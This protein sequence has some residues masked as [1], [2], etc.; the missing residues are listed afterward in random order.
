MNIRKQTKRNAKLIRG[1]EEKLDD[2]Y[3]K[4]REAEIER[5]NIV[6]RTTQEY[7]EL[8]RKYTAIVAAHQ[9][10]MDITSNMH[11]QLDRLRAAVNEY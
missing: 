11:Y 2:L 9:K 1:Y 6:R 7:A 4:L 10:M 5:L 8:E 3:C